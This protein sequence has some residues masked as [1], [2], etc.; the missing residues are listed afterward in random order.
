[1]IVMISHRTG[2]QLR[3]VIVGAGNRP[4]AREVGRA[5][6]DL[7][8]EATRVRVWADGLSF[9]DPPTVDMAADSPRF[10]PAGPQAQAFAVRLTVSWRAELTALRLRE[11]SPEASPGT[12]DWFRELRAHTALGGSAVQIYPRSDLTGHGRA[13]TS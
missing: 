5:V 1:M 13:R 10:A 12:P 11:F 7:L 8:G 2:A 3:T 6:L 4:P 9:T